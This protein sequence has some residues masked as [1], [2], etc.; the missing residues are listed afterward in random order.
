MKA[1]LLGALSLHWVAQD[2]E[3]FKA[4]AAGASTPPL[5]CSVPTDAQCPHTLPPWDRDPE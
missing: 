3:A 4:A 2:T 1:Q 5:S